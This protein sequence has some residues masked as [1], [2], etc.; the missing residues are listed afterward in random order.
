MH[1]TDEALYMPCGNSHL[2]GTCIESLR[3]GNHI[4]VWQQMGTGAW[5]FAASKEEDVSKHHM[6]IPDGYNI[7]R[8]WVVQQSQR[9]KNGVTSFMFKTCE[10]CLWPLSRSIDIQ[11][12]S[13][14]SKN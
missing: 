2:F 4:R 10:L 12:Q 13:E 14:G 7:G 3:G 6:I 9:N 5:F 1:A 11:T 8:D